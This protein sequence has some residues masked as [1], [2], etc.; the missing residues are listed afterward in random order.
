MTFWS[1]FIQLLYLSTT[2]VILDILKTSYLGTSSFS[3]RF[4]SAI[5]E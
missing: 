1:S 4:F 3:D 5:L 2:D